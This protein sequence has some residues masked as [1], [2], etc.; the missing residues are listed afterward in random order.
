MEREEESKAITIFVARLL[1]VVRTLISFPAGFAQMSMWRFQSYT[2]MG[3][4]IWCFALAYGGLKFGQAWQSNPQFQRITHGL[5]I[6][7]A[8]GLGLGV[9]WYARKVWL[10]FRP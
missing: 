9:L 1:P 5:N 6:V 2:F 8:A 4:V 3:S 10:H 7:I